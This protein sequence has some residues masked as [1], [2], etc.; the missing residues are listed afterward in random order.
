MRRP[1]R[2]PPPAAKEGPRVNKEIRV[3]EVQLID[4]DG[5]NLGAVPIQQALSRLRHDNP[6]LSKPSLPLARPLIAIMMM[7]RSFAS[8]SRNPLDTRTS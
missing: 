7:A 4:A 8:P 1:H 2:A 6:K 5:N 3:S